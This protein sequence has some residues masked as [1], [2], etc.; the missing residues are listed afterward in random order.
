MMVQ[1]GH[2]P[3]YENWKRRITTIV[4]AEGRRSKAS[5]F[6]LFDFGVYDELTTG[7]VPE[8]GLAEFYFEASHFTKALGDHVLQRA[9]SFPDD[10]SHIPPGGFGRLLRSESI[11]THLEA[12]R[13]AQKNYQTTHSEELMPLR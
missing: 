7:T 6:P 1:T 11:G 8:R 5:P 12:I 13:V 9:L 10:H 4:E 3:T 2:W